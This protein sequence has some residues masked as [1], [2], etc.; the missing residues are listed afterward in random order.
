MSKLWLSS[1][2]HLGHRNICK[3]RQNF[4][5][6]EEHHNTIFENLAT[7][8]GKRDTLYLLGDIAFDKFWLQKVAELKVQH[9]VLICGNHDLENGI[10]MRDLVPIYDNIEVLWSKRNY[11]FSHCPIHPQ[12]IRNRLG[13]IHGHLHGNM[14][15]EDEV[16]IEM[17]GGGSTYYSPIDTRYINVC[18]EHTDWKPITFAEAT[19]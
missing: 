13:N 14:V 7:S 3:Y 8:V 10:K 17:P 9:K 16:E 2:L 4:S 12:E 11:W 15:W 5:S 6:A 18:V 19:A 1:D